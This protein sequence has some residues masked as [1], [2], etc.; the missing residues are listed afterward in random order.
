[1]P[2]NYCIMQIWAESGKSA[3]PICN[4]SQILYLFLTFTQNLK[5]SQK[6]HDIHFD[7]YIMS[8]FL[9]KQSHQYIIDFL[10]HRKLVHH[11]CRHSLPDISTYFFIT[12][13]TFGSFFLP[14]LF[15]HL[16]AS[17]YLDSVGDLPPHRM[18][19]FCIGLRYRNDHFH[20]F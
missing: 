2:K 10:R 20:I 5:R 6:R 17:Q 3:L 16:P 1:M 4:Y 19:K 13:R 18:D 11:L 9:L 7:V 15:S 8:F 12:E 14:F